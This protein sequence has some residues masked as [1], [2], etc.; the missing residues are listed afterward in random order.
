MS[1]ASTAST[2]AAMDADHKAETKLIL[3]R[4]GSAPSLRLCQSFED[5]EDI[6]EGLPPKKVLA[7]WAEMHEDAQMAEKILG[8][9]K[10]SK[11]SWN[12]HI[13]QL[14]KQAVDALYACG[15]FSVIVWEQV[16]EGEEFELNPESYW[17]RIIADAEFMATR[18]RVPQHRATVGR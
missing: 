10:E 4:I 18:P 8:F 9:D 15:E 14:R 2:A 11:I 5:M 17:R 7:Y 12:Q 13:S 6:A 16:S 3:E 1:T